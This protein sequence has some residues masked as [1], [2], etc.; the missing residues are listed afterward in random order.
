MSRDTRLQRTIRRAVDRRLQEDKAR[1][2]AP[3]V[4]LVLKI[5][6]ALI[7]IPGIVT[8]I[9]SLLPRLSISPQS[10]LISSN[11]FSAPFIVSND[12]FFP[13]YK[14][15][16]VCSPKNV[17]YMEPGHPKHRVDLQLQ[18]PDEDE[19]GGL[20]DTELEVAELLPAHKNAF[21]C[22]LLGIKSTTVPPE[23]LAS[24]HIL[25]IVRYH[26]PLLPFLQRYFRQRFELSRDSSG[27]YRWIEQPFKSN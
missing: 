14:V 22:V 21:P 15:N 6:V 19:T 25:M 18:G 26:T 8:S 5:V 2:K 1:Q 16:A 23:W 4:K 20:L 9:L 12:S 7:G 3:R 11:A 27:Q 17:S 24:A 10:P 13:L